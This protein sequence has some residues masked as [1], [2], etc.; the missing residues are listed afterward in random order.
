MQ[1]VDR[2]I[3]RHA[4]SGDVRREKGGGTPS[5]EGDD[6]LVDCIGDTRVVDRHGGHDDRA[7]SKNPIKH[8]IVCGKLAIE[9]ASC[10]SPGSLFPGR[11]AV[12]SSE[13]SSAGFCC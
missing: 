7:A 6:D 1:S 11:E 2:I 8:A 3:V 5:A 13:R 9:L 4:F 12:L 10:D